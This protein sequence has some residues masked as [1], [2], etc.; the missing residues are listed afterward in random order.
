RRR[1]QH[2]TVP[3]VLAA[4]ALVVPVLIAASLTGLVRFG[5]GSGLCPVRRRC[6]WIADPRGVDRRAHLRG[7]RSRSVDA[8]SARVESVTA[9]ARRAARPGAVGDALDRA[10]CL[11]T[12]HADGDAAIRF[13]PSA[14]PLAVAIAGPGLFVVQDGGR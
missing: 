12:A 2:P 4:A 7:T 9:D 11:I 1:A 3:S 10:D 5:A 6:W 13:A 8:L 14:S